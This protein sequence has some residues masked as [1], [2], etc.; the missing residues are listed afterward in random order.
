M[1]SARCLILTIARHRRPVSIVEVLQ[2]DPWGSYCHRCQT[3][4]PKCQ[5]VKKWLTEELAPLKETTATAHFSWNIQFWLNIIYYRN[6]SYLESMWY[7]PVKHP[8]VRYTY[9]YKYIILIDISKYTPTYYS[10]KRF[11]IWFQ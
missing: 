9:L 10:F 3:W 6:K 5:W 4:I 11:L 8:Y 1:S 7:P 2:G